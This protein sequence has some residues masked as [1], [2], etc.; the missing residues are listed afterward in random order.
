LKTSTVARYKIASRAIL[1]NAAIMFG[2]NANGRNDL[3]LS[4]QEHCNNPEKV[5]SLYFYKPQNL[6]LSEPA[7]AAPKSEE[8]V[9]LASAPSLS[10]PIVGPAITSELIH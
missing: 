2:D 4:L 3:D 7:Y 9:M 1:A 10:P 5:S 6:G 8:A